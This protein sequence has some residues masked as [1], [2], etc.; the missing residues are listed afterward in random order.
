MR[1][2]GNSPSGSKNAN[3]RQYLSFKIEWHIFSLMTYFFARKNE[4]CS[5]CRCFKNLFKILKLKR[6][7]EGEDYSYV[8]D[9]LSA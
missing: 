6:N 7:Y 2:I 5:N 8:E 1:I 9:Q 3:K 4:R